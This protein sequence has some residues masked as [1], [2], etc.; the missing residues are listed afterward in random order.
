MVNSLRTEPVPSPVPARALR[1]T[2]QKWWPVLLAALGGALL[3]KA[4]PPTSWWPLAPV[5]IGLLLVAL[6]RDSVPWALTSG[7]A[8]GLAF[9]LQHVWWATVSVGQPIG[10]IALALAQASFISGFAGAWVWVRRIRWL[11]GHAGRQVIA[12]TIVWVAVERFRGRWPFGGFPWG[13]LAFSQTDGPLLRLAPVAGTTLVGA[14]VVLIGAAAALLLTGRRPL[15]RR[16]AL[17][18]LTAVVLGLVAARGVVLPTSAQDGSL[19]VGA[20]QGNV[21]SSDLA[22]R[23]RALQ[24]IANHVAGTQSLLQST[25]AG[26]VDLVLWPES[27]S[28]IDP[29]VDPQ[30]KALVDGAAREARAPILLGTQR[31]EPDRRYNDY[32]LWQ[33]GVGSVASYTKQHPVPF[34]EYVPYRSFF[35]RFVPAVDK[36]SRDMAPG[37]GTALVSVPVP[38]LGRSVP[39]TTVICFEVAYDDLIRQSVLAGTEAIIIP[40]NNAS[41]GRTQEAVQQLAMSRFRAAEHNRAVVQIS[42]VGVSA[43]IAPD[44]AVLQR[45]GLFTAEQMRADLPLRTSITIADRLGEWPGRLVDALALALL[46]ASVVARVRRTR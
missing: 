8:F 29:R 35:R 7:G 3:E 43:V 46:A 34:G 4:F 24:V 12:V 18:T 40:T 26:A 15:D 19:R 31:L 37:K 38:R 27:A 9:F 20:V 14:A 5:A 36:I 39:L 10:W 42:T 16:V 44:G 41:F 2:W 33:P 25:S 21:P 1:G 13:S 11:R 28:D 23:D 17:A 6:G 45:T 32:I 22:D 30:V